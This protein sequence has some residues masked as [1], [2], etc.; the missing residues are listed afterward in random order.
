M[1]IPLKIDELCPDGAR[2]E[3]NWRRFVVGSS[4]FI[5]CVDVDTARKQVQK[6]ATRKCMKVKSVVRVENGMYGVRFWRVL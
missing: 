5:P 6:V 1:G 3:V 4:I 2:I